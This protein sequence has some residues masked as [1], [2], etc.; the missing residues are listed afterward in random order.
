MEEAE[1]DILEAFCP[2]LVRSDLKLTLTHLANIPVVCP[3]ER[4]PA[5]FASGS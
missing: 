5:R 2:V 3:T 4:E 1:N